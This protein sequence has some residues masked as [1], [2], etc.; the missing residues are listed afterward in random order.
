MSNTDKNIPQKVFR[1][2]GTPG[3]E[4]KSTKEKRISGI[5]RL[6]AIGAAA[7]AG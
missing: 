6:V 4:E 1:L 7:L 5:K 3:N 2:A